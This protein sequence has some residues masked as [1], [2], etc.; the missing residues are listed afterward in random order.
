MKAVVTV[1]GKDQI[2]IIAKV[3]CTLAENSMN[4]LDISQTI[5]QDYF[6]MIMIVDLSKMKSSF[7]DIKKEL[8]KVGKDIGLSIKIQHEDIFDSMHKIS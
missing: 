3:T 2:G 6:T 5:L 7:N 4:I 1:I 8:E